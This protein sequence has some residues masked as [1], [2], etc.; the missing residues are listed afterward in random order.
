MQ[1][2]LLDIRV[3]ESPK[4]FRDKQQRKSFWQGI[5]FLKQFNEKVSD[6]EFNIF[7]CDLNGFYKF[8]SESRY[9]ISD[10]IEAH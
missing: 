2:L 5:L 3:I 1:Y 6:C 9:L 8:H 10:G 4:D 7:Q